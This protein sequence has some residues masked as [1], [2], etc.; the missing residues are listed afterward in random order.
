M[1]TIRF[2][3]L[4]CRLNQAEESIFAADFAANGWLVLSESGENADVVVL[5]SCAVTRQA[6]RSTLQKLRSFKRGAVAGHIPVVAVTGC[7]AAALPET[8]LRDAGADVIVLRNGYSGLRATI[9]AFF[10]NSAKPAPLADGECVGAFP[11]GDA[12]AATEAPTVQLP[13]PDL[14][15]HPFFGAD[16]AAL[17]LPSG[18]RRAMLKVQDG[19]D[20]RCAY[21]IVPFTR[22]AAVS[23]PFGESVDAA[24]ALAESGAAEIVLTGCN[25]ACYRSGNAG[26]PELARAVCEAVLPFGA[27]VS[28]GSVEPAICDEGIVEAMLAEQ[29]FRRFLHLPIQSGDSG[30][31]ALAGRRYD[32]PAIRRIIQLYRDSVP[33]LELGGDFITGLP[34]ED[35]A[36]FA[37]TCALVRDFAFDRLHIFPYSPR[38]GT[39]ALAQHDAPSRAVAKDRAAK[40]RAMIANRQPLI[41]NCEFL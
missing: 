4:G 10:A 21:C 3:T 26:L 41:A 20:F 28:F 1:R 39:A 32:G 27:K 11:A 34:G 37:N 22:G 12:G 7:A 2:E 35:E 40:L 36:A 16:G 23:R 29:N 18:R 31:L 8:I 17:A 14:A 6:E 24:R 19:C 5:H 25:L 13:V 33:G 30:V 15:P 9:E 38:Q